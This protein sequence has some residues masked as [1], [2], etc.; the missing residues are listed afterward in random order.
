VSVDFRVISGDW[1]R[2]RAGDRGQEVPHQRVG[3]AQLRGAA[4]PDRHLRPHLPGTRG[5]HVGPVRCHGGHFAAG[6]GGEEVADHQARGLDEDEHLRAAAGQG[7]QRA[8]GP[9]RRDQR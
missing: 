3:Q 8:S 9:R 4:G 2:R 5:P 1:A 7:T 6:A